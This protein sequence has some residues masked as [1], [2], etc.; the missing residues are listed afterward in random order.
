MDWLSQN[1]VWIALTVGGFFLFTRM[2]V[3]GCGMGGCGMGGS[4]GSNRGSAGNGPPIDQGAG[5]RNAFDPVSRHPLPVGAAISSMYRG[6][7]Y[8]FESRENRDAFENDP[9]KYLA[10]SPAAAGQ[11]IGSETAGSGQPARRS[12]CC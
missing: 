5:P 1:W 8:Y 12:G 9:E 7:A 2:G 6:R 10:A 3:G 11:A 4:M